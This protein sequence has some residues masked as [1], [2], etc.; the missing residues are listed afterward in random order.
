MECGAA[1]LSLMRVPKGTGNNLIGR[2][3]RLERSSQTVPFASMNIIGFL[4][5][6]FVDGFD[7]MLLGPQF[8]GKVKIV[9][10]RVKTSLK[11]LTTIKGKGKDHE[12]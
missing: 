6:M 2:F 9:P 5:A 1:Y 7:G 11:A 3:P 10:V 4:V 12:K 8:P